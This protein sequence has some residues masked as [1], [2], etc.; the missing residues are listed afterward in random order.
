MATFISGLNIE[1]K[2][3]KSVLFISIFKPL[4][5]IAVWLLKHLA[6]IFIFLYNEKKFN[7]NNI[8]LTIN[9]L[10]HSGLFL[11]LKIVKLLQEVYPES[12]NKAGTLLQI[13]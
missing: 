11:I 5:K 6:L 12:F 1:N 3:A 4:M 10:K 9:L 2:S 13:A 8:I 7:M